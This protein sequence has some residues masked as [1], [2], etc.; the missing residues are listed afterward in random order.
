MDSLHPD[1]PKLITLREAFPLL[2]IRPTLGYQLSAR[3]CIPG[4]VRVAGVMRVH[5]PTLLA[6]IEAQAAASAA[7]AKQAR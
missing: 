4:Q 1:A 6:H 2:G 7:N 5:L 3:D